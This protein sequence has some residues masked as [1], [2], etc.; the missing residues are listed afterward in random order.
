MTP[1]SSTVKPAALPKPPRDP[2][3]TTEPRGLTEAQSRPADLFNTAAV[4]GRSAALDVCVCVWHLPLQLQPEG[5]AAQ[6]AF[7]R[8]ISH[9]RHEISD[10][11]GRSF[12]APWCGQQTVAHAQQLPQPCSTPQTLQR[13]VMVNKCQQNLFS[14]DGSMTSK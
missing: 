4:P 8:K 6:A 3:I 13:S 5:D 11:R 9:Y 1:N 7:D 10:L 2:G 14:K 12:A